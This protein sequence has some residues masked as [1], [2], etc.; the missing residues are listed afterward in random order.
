MYS[1]KNILLFYFLLTTINTAHDSFKNE[2]G[3]YTGLDDTVMMPTYE[4]CISDTAQDSTGKK[5]CFLQGEKDLISRTA[6]VLIEDES[7]SRIDLIT[8]MSEVATKL[9]VDCISQ[10]TFTSDCGSSSPNN[11]DDCKDS[12]IDEYCCYVKIESK[13]FNGSACRKFDEIN[14]NIIGEAVVAAKTIDAKLE[15]KCTKGSFIR[16]NVFIFGILFVLGVF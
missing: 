8:E 9:K 10:K 6:C 16:K 3:P 15:V 7:S 14:N 5:C 2:C 13:Q 4:E 12:S 11:M 1:L